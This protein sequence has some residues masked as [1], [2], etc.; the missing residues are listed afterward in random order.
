MIYSV[1][2][3]Y[4]DEHYPQSF[5]HMSLS[6]IPASV[7]IYMARLFLSAVDTVHLAKTC[8]AFSAEGSSSFKAELERLKQ[9]SLE[10][11]DGFIAAC[12]DGEEYFIDLHIAK[13]YATPSQALIH[14]VRAPSVN[15]SLITKYKEAT[16][17]DIEDIN[18][19][20]AIDCALKYA[21]NRGLNNE[22]TS[23]LFAANSLVRAFEHLL[24]LES[25]RRWYTAQATKYDLSDLATADEVMMDAVSLC[26]VNPYTAIFFNPALRDRIM[27]LEARSS[28]YWGIDE[29]SVSVI[30][31]LAFAYLTK[32]DPLIARLKELVVNPGL[33]ERVKIVRGAVMSRSGKHANDAITVFG[34]PLSVFATKDIDDDVIPVL[35]AVL[36]RQSKEFICA[37]LSMVEQMHLFRF[38]K[39]VA[40]AL[41]GIEMF[42]YLMGLAYTR[43]DVVAIEFLNKEYAVALPTFG[44]QSVFTD[45]YGFDYVHPRM[46]CHML[47][48]KMRPSSA[49]KVFKDTTR[50]AHLLKMKPRVMTYTYQ[51]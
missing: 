18:N 43:M 38:I 33:E 3:M 39:D 8:R 31:E 6:I 47:K 5:T 1:D 23:Q 17:A 13:G 50:C 14:C 12:R 19:N 45:M 4:V 21:L 7:V 46:V 26:I 16:A 42:T 34:C 49:W 10:C 27:Q 32:N 11:A 40:K 35:S 48:A 20:A 51:A 24:P 9:Y 41:P 30:D 2:I 22:A 36:V 25:S 37:T 44:N 29:G 28:E 15:E